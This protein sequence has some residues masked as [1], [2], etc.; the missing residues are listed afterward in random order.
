MPREV[1]GVSV[2][3]VSNVRVFGSVARG[4]DT[5]DSDIDVL[6]DVSAGTGLFSLSRL[7]EP[8]GTPSNYERVVKGV[9][10]R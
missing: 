5:S 7:E 8:G 4:A 10:R 6:V 1:H 9:L 3:G 2:H